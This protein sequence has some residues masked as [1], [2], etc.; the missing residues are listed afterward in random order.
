[1]MTNAR[2]LARRR[3]M[4][5]TT[6]AGQTVEIDL[7]AFLLQEG[8]TERDVLD[9]VIAA[10]EGHTADDERVRQYLSRR[11]SARPAAAPGPRWNA[12]MP[13]HSTPARPVPKPAGQDRG[14]AGAR[15]RAAAA[16]TALLDMRLADGT[17]LRHAKRPALLASAQAWRQEADGA[18]ARATFVERVAQRLRDDVVLVGGQLSESEL[19]EIAEQDRGAVA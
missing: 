1:M 14:L 17:I 15:A 9:C 8:L 6:P 16:V 3:R 12:G 13:P 7:G 19:A 2:W 10:S 18:L 4:A 11:G 5:V